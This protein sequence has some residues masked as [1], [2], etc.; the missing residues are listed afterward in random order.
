MVSTLEVFL[1]NFIFVTHFLI[2]DI[3]NAISYGLFCYSEERA[4]G[5]R[6]EFHLFFVPRK[7]QLCEKWLKVGYI[8]P[9]YN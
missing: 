2:D 4:S 8:S 7:S 6:K 5:F 1:F 3:M 9:C